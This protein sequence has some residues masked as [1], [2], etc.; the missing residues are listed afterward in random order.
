MALVTPPVFDLLYHI[1]SR[2]REMLRI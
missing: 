2:R 1:P